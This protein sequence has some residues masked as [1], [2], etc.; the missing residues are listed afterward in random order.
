MRQTNYKMFCPE[1]RNYWEDSQEQEKCPYCKSN[2][3]IST[4]YIY[5]D[6]GQKVYLT[7]ESNK[8]NKCGLSYNYYGQKTQLSSWKFKKAKQCL[9]DN[10]IEA[11]ESEIVLQA[12][13]Y[14]LLDEES[15]QYF[16]N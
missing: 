3:V 4:P 9:I 8:C 15:E 16:E 1:C 6:C 7:E 12:L 5:C 2:E 13:I 11:D 10:G 14:I